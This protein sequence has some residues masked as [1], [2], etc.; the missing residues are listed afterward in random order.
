MKENNEPNGALFKRDKILCF[1]YPPMKMNIGLDLAAC[2]KQCGKYFFE[3]DNWKGRYFNVAEVWA[4][5]D[6]VLIDMEEKSAIDMHKEQM[7]FAKIF[8]EEELNVRRDL[9]TII[10]VTL[11]LIVLYYFVGGVFTLFIFISAALKTF[12]FD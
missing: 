9:L 1:S 2:C 12:L 4:D 7:E 10:L 8:R 5:Q 11:I 6:K 3:H